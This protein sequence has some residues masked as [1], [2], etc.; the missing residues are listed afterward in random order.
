MLYYIRIARVSFDNKEWT[1]IAEFHHV[2]ETVL[3]EVLQLY[4]KAGLE[5]KVCKEDGVWRDPI[6]KE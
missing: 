4:G 3:L 6:S 1:L 2:S 5:I